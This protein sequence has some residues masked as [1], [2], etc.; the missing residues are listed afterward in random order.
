[1]K[2]EIGKQKIETGKW[3]FEYINRVADALEIDAEPETQAALARGRR[4]S[5][6]QAHLASVIHPL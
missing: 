5:R 2:I 6:K 3:K 1:M 4:H